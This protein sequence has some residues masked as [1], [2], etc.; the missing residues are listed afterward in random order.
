MLSGCGVFD[1]SEIHEATLTLYFLAKHGADA[2]CMAPDRK[3]LDVV[4]HRTKEP[5]GTSRNVLDESARIARGNIRD[6]DAVEE[7]EIDGIIV[8]GGFG[9]AKNL[10]TFAKDGPECEVDA[11]VARL[12]RD[13]HARRKPIGALCIAPALLARLFG[14]EC[15][16]E[17][18]I[19]TDPATAAAVEKLGARHR[20]ATCDEIVVDEKNRIVTTPCYMTA[21]GIQEVGT[22]IEKVV[23]KI[24]QIASATSSRSAGA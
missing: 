3:Q 22:G 23:L 4:N 1:G 21:P 14:A 2:V 19:G 8:P 9:A 7:S 18:T 24:L 13:L 12:L 20:S 15:H 16:V 10:S 11:S 5:S 17:L 6:V